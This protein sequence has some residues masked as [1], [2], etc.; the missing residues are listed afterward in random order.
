MPSEPTEAPFCFLRF[1][2]SLWLLVVLAP[3]THAGAS[4]TLTEDE[5]T[6]VLANGAVSVCIEKRTGN[7]TSMVYEGIDLLQKGRGYW[8]FVGSGSRLGGRTRCE[9][10]ED[11]AKNGGERAEVMCRFEYDP[12]TGG[13]PLNVDFCYSLGRNQH[14]VY[15][16]AILHHPADYPSLSFGE[17]RYALKLNPGIFDY[18]TIDARRSRLMPTGEDWDRASPLNLKEARRLTSGHDAGHAEHKYG[19][20]AILSEV[21]AYGWSSTK[22]R[23]GLWMINPSMEYIA[24]GPTKV[25]LTGHLDV[26]PG[27]APTLLNMWLGSHYGGSSLR[28]SQGETWTK[29]VGPFL[30]HSNRDGDPEALW[31]SALAEAEKEKAAWPY[32]WL[33]HEA[34]PGLAERAS[35]SGEIVV[36]GEATQPK[37]MRVGLVPL[38]YEVMTRSGRELVSWQRDAKYYQ[39]WAETDADGRFS[40]RHVRPGTYELHAFGDG[41]LGE[42]VKSPVIIKAAEVMDLGSLAWTPEKFGETIW[43]IGIPNRTAAEFRHGDHYWQWGLYFKYAEEFPSDVTFIVGQSDWRRDWNYAQPPRIDARGRVQGASTWRIRFD[44]PKARQGRATLRLGIAG[45]RTER[46]IL[47]SVNDSAVGGT[48]PLPDTGVMHRDGIQGYWVER[49]VPFDA[50]LLREGRNEIALTVPARSWVQGVL[51]DYI[52]LEI[53]D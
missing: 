10:R 51:Y 2:V 1:F 49:R 46:G 7:L 43:D 31:K 37:R 34:Y 50:A 44:L 26:N 17:A 24:G 52:R 6:F 4:V 15:A 14:G 36:K 25:E 32:P 33:K 16:F 19:Y 40:I 18:M 53:A 45:S 48:G 12:Q 11:P 28:V 23:V 27:G 3:A 35:V 8:S 38:E 22:K 29:C 13:I 42:F 39:F 30:I 41:I 20:S 9:V 21:P 47:V 5:R